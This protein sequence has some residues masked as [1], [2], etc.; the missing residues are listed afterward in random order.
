[1]KNKWLLGSAAIIVTMLLI[2]IIYPWFVKIPERFS[3]SEDGG[4]VYDRQQNLIWKRC[5]EGMVW[6]GK[7]CSG[8]ALSF[9]YTDALTYAKQQT[10]WHLSSVKELSS[11]IDHSRKPTLNTIAFPNTHNFYWSATAHADDP[12]IAWGVFLN[13]GV[14]FDQKKSHKGYLRLVKPMTMSKQ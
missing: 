3:F 2:F 1:M 6:D 13:N 5:D 7:T 4:L 14:V 8:E 9:T 11:L 12:E 10:S